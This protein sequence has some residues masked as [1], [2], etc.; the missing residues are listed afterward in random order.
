MVAVYVFLGLRWCTHSLL[1]SLTGDNCWIITPLRNSRV[2]TSKTLAND[3]NYRDYQRTHLY[4]QEP[5]NVN[6]IESS[7]PSRFSRE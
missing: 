4:T 3:S 1:K 5:R 7:H 6:D 2:L